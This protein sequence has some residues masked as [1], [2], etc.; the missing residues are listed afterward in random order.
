MTDATG[1]Q[2]LQPMPTPLPPRPEDH[3]GADLTGTAARPPMLGTLPPRP[4][5]P[6]PVNR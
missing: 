2:A 1:T 4:L 3:G 6:A 5:T